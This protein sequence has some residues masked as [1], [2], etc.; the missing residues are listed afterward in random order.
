MHAIKICLKTCLPRVN[1]R[2][3]ILLR[4]Y[5]HPNK[6]P[7]VF[8][9]KMLCLFAAHWWFYVYRACAETSIGTFITPEKCKRYSLS[10]SLSVRPSVLCL[11]LPLS[12]TLT[13]SLSERQRKSSATYV[14]SD[15]GQFWSNVSPNQITHDL[16]QCFAI[17]CKFLN[18]FGVELGYQVLIFKIHTDQCRNLDEPVA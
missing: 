11:S 1:L 15:T 18:L 5:V 10:E 4:G 14:I 2:H 9:P 7:V 16:E 8:L 13:L 17:S 6:Q 12:L 3:I